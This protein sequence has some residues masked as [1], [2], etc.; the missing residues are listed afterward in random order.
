MADY[1]KSTHLTARLFS[2]NIRKKTILFRNHAYHAQ[3][4]AHSL[5]K[6]YN[7]KVRPF[8]L[9]VKTLVKQ[10]LYNEYPSTINLKCNELFTRGLP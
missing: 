1:P 4:E 6:K 10:G 3:I 5:V 8:A 2:K 9:K 7:E